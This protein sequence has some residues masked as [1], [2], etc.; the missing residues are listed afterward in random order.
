MGSLVKF[1]SVF[2]FTLQSKS[3]KLS[4]Y[5]SKKKKIGLILLIN[6]FLSF[7]NF[8][9]ISLFN[10]NIYVVIF[11]FKFGPH[12]FECYFFRFFWKNNFF[13]I[14]SFDIGFV[15]NLAPC[16]FLDVVILVSWPKS[17]VWKINR[18]LQ[19]LFLHYLFSIPSFHVGFF[20]IQIIHFIRVTSL[21]SW[22]GLTQVMFFFLYFFL[23]YPST[24]KCFR[25]DLCN[26]IRFAF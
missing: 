2:N 16:V 6:S 9:S 21:T 25:F 7:Y 3:Y 13:S 15:R 12:Y 11:Y 5:F 18:G 19:Q 17:R 26:F 24:L 4:S 20:G 14:S 22:L 23:F 1:K 10:Q 8:F